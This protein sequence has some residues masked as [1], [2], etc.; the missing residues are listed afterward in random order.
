MKG[1]I[2]KAFASTI[3]MP[4]PS[5]AQKVITEVFR[6]Q[7]NW[8]LVGARLW[9]Q[10]ISTVIANDGHMHLH[11]Y[12]TPRANYHQDGEIIHAEAF[13]LWNTTPA[14]VDYECEDNIVMFPDGYG[15]SLPEEAILNVVYDGANVSAAAIDMTYAGVL[16]LVSGKVTSR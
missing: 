11:A 10:F 4:G 16:Y 13:V 7:E 6:A 14:A 8:I 15:I 2:T 1:I 12:L 3:V 5:P 9:W